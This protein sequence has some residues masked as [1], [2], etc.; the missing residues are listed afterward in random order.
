[1]THLLTFC[2]EAA[3][4]LTLEDIESECAFLGGHLKTL[5]DHPPRIISEVNKNAKYNYPFKYQ[6]L[7]PKLSTEIIS[8]QMLLLL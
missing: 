7:L 6:V 8:K 3:V 4:G 2:R 5:P 1:M